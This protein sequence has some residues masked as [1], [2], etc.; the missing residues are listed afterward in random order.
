VRPGNPSDLT[1]LPDL[2]RP[3][4]RF[5]N[6]QRGAGTRVWLDAQ[7]HRRRMDPAQI[8]GYGEEKPTHS[9]V[10]RAVA[11]EHADVGLGVEAAA[12]AYGLGFVLLTSERYDLVIPAE[13]RRQDPVQALAQWLAT[14]DARAAITGLG[15]YDTAKMGSVTWIG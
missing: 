3:G 15:G 13:V 8:H 10:A 11:E 9:E 7:L 2:A 1:D 5:V 14:D 6:R 4:L 12:L